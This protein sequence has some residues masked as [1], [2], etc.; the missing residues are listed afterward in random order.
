M[1]VNTFPGSYFSS[2]VSKFKSNINKRSRTVSRIVRDLFMIFSRFSRVFRGF[3]ACSDL[4]GPV[5]IHSDAFGCIRT[6]SDTFGSV[7]KR[8]DV[9]GFF[10]ISIFFALVSNTGEAN[11]E[12]CAPTA[13]KISEICSLKLEIDNRLR[14]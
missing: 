4:F 7:R 13:L 9:F 5:R 2:F 10:I 1:R 3:R 14:R 12:M 8:V 6:R 11:D